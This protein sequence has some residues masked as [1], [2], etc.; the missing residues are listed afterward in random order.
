MRLGSSSDLGEIEAIF[1]GHRELEL[2]GDVCTIRFWINAA[3][4]HSAREFAGSRKAAIEEMTCC[5]V[6]SGPAQP[7]RLP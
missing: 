5:E 4:V 6:L 1:S 3:D 7:V 2:E